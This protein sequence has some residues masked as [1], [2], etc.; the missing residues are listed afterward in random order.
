MQSRGSDVEVALPLY[1]LFPDPGL[2]MEPVWVSGILCFPS[3]KGWLGMPRARLC[4]PVPPSE[5]LKAG[6]HRLMVL[7][8][9]SVLARE[10]AI[11]HCP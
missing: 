1:H 6:T 11:A 5:Q 4:Q 2:Q 10:P 8:A 7:S 3:L 9:S